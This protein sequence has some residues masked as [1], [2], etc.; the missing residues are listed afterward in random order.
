MILVV[1]DGVGSRGDLIG[2]ELIGD[3][4]PLGSLI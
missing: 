2:D 3:E 1:A 4:L